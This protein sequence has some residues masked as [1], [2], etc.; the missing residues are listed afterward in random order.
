MRKIVWLASYPKSGNTWLR[1]LLANYRSE[2]AEAADIN[3]LGDAS[4]FAR[5]AFDA[6]LGIKSATLPVRTVE[7]FR[8]EI[9]RAIARDGTAPMPIK[10]HDRWRRTDRGEPVFPAEISIGAIYIL[11]NALDVAPSAAH[12]WGLSLEASVD[13]MADEAVTLAGETTGLS[14]TLPQPMGGWSGHIRSWI[15]ESG[16]PVLLVRYED[17]LADTAGELARIVAFC[18]LQVDAARIDHAVGHS[19]FDALRAQEGDTGFREHSAKARGSF[20]RQGRAGGWRDALPAPLVRRLI[21][22]HGDMLC[23]FGYLDDKGNPVS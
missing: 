23:R 22:T 9:Y 3:A 10:I 16:L 2:S 4:G 15:D 5:A 19:R 21:D 18:G 20:F 14:P 12:H 13:R 17:L 11:R 8:P 1:I 7:R 6:R